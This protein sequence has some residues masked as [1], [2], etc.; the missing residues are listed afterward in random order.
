MAGSLSNGV[1]RKKNALLEPR[2]RRMGRGGEKGA[3]K[4]ILI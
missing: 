2:R 3:M 4:E 1:P